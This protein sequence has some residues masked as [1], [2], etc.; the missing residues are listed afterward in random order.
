MTTQGLLAWEDFSRDLQ[1]THSIDV[2]LSCYSSELTIQTLLTEEDVLTFNNEV[3]SI[4][5]SLIVSYLFTKQ[6]SL[7]IEAAIHHWSII[8]S[9]KEFQ[10][11]QFELDPGGD[12][13]DPEIS[14]MLQQIANLPTS[15]SELTGMQEYVLFKMSGIELGFHF[16][17]LIL[18]AIQLILAVALVPSQ[19][20]FIQGAAVSFVTTG[21]LTFLTSMAYVTAGQMTEDEFVDE[22]LGTLPSVGECIW[23]AVKAAPLW[24]KVALGFLAIASLGI[25]V[26]ELLGDALSAGAVTAV[27]IA[28]SAV[29][30]ILYLWDF[31]SDMVDD[32]YLVG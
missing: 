31:I 1:C 26:A 9:K 14:Q 5:G 7:L 21:M 13:A 23:K 30:I 18:L 16:I 32:D 17:S 29:L 10:P 22:F 27:R 20:S 4:F 2:V 24:E 19:F 11:L 25:L 6:Q 15:Y 28:I 3:D 12:G 8:K